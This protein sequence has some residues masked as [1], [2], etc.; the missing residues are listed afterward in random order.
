[1]YAYT[2]MP[3]MQNLEELL[4][5]AGLMGSFDLFEMFLLVTLVRYLIN[6]G[7]HNL[8]IPKPFTKGSPKRIIVKLYQS[9][10]Y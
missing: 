3:A 9:F 10:G 2:S 7:V 1:M 6:R 8:T 5:E 4:D